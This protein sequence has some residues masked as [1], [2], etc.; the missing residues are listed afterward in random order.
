MI[1]HSAS[2][3]CVLN[4]S[5]RG[6]TAFRGPRVVPVSR[7]QPPDFL[8][9]GGGLAVAAGGA[10]GGGGED[11]GEVGGVGGSEDVLVQ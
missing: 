6:R 8:L 3:V 11:R 7:F 5:G 9:D 1:L 4:H 2:G 10:G